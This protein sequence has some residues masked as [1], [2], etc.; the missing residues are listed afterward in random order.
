[1][2]RITIGLF[3]SLLLIASAVPQVQHGTTLT[4]VASTTAGVTYNVY[5]GT[6]STGESI[7]AQNASPITGTTYFDAVTLGA[8]P[9]TFYYYVE[10]VETSGTITVN[11]IPSNEVS[12]TFP[13]TP[14]PATS[15]VA[16]PK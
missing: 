3:A 9:Q 10:A 16:T 13:G 2:K 12:A 8:S 14:T 4:W 7:I 1:M 15:L 11:S 5:R 6:T